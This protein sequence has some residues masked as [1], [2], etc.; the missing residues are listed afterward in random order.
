MRSLTVAEALNEALHEEF[1]RDP[2]TLVF[3]EDIAD[4]GGLFGV[5][6]G[7]LDRFGPRRVFGTPISEQAI[8]GAAVG[9]ALVGARPIAE[10]QIMD[11]LTL[12]MD[13]IVNHAAKL[14]YMTGGQLRVPLVIRG[15]V[16][17]GVG[18]AAQHSQSLEAWFVHIPG[19]KVVMP[20]TPADAKGLLKSAIRDPNPVIF[21]EKRVL[22]AI[23]GDV[24]T[25]EHLVPLGKAEVCRTGRDV[26][27]LAS[28]LSAHYGR[29]AAQ[30]LAEQGI[31]VEL[32]DLRTLKPLDVDTIVASVRKTGR[33]IVANDG[34]RTCGFA[35]ELVS[36][37][38][39]EAFDYLDA[40][41]VRVAGA[42]A[43]IPYAQNLEA[44][45][46]VTT[47]KLIRAVR[48][49]VGASAPAAVR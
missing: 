20:S 41:I 7:L 44:E 8:A 31:D 1:E 23:R 28:G 29:D 25:G 21:F 46:L 4:T 27:L 47:D 11:F 45:V 14:R 16:G 35:A 2:R 36:T 9:A 40:P 37:L 34:Y 42:D 49:L 15:P 3:G 33:V 43:P 12:A 30:K 13:Q 38:V 24:P 6:R 19:L 48:E 18:L 17:A 10:I 22:Y 5:T 39:E 26:T 32:I